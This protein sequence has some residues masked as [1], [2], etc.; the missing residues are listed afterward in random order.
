MKTL[1]LFVL[2]VVVL[3]VGSAAAQQI[4]NTPPRD[5]AYDKIA[6]PEKKPI[7]YPYLRQADVMWEKRVWRI[8][9]VEQKMN[10]S[11][12]YPEVP[13]NN[14]KNFMT[15]IIDALKE[16]TITA[17]EAGTPGDDFSVPLTYKGLLEK[18]EKADTQQLQRPYPPYDWYD[19]IIQKKLNSAEVKRFRIKED[20]I[21]DAQRSQMI[22]RII[23]VC[24]VRQRY[25][26][27]GEYRGDEELFWINFAEAR[28][29][30][31][32]AEV[33]NR[34]N[35]ASKMTYD[36]LF[37]KRFFSSY[38]YKID[39]VYD[40]RIA[41]YATGIDIMLESERIKEELFNFE[42]NLWEY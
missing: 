31:A 11:F 38:I 26:D 1:K 13:H 5:G 24:P 35:S 2:F 28:P 39:N 29:V 22:F 19:T 34:Q 23:G 30:F 20:M 4:T 6:T 21:F 40:R 27:A 36:D 16:G 3:L 32:K 33:F 41:E 42:Q 15:V 7:A 14:W 12:F 37:W 9:D 17:Y 10:Q 18:I 25:S 8:I